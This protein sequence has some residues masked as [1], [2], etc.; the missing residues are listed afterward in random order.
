MALPSGIW[1]R[2]VW[3]VFTDVQEDC[4]ATIFWV[5]ERLHDITFQK[6]AIFRDTAVRTSY[7]M[8][9]NVF[10]TEASPKDRPSCS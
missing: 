6:T 8:Q 2:V 7:L 1:R 4:T 10:P 9:V 3:R 5:K